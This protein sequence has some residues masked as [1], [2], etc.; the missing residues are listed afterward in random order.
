MDAFKD[1][2]RSIEIPIKMHGSPL[3][4][5]DNSRF[6]I[7]LFVLYD[8]NPNAYLADAFLPFIRITVCSMPRCSFAGRARDIFL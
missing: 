4:G 7:A 3:R 2:F 1:G 8:L 6:E 5:L